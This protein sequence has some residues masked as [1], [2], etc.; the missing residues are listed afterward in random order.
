MVCGPWVDLY[1][2][3]YTLQYRGRQ[4]LMTHDTFALRDHKMWRL[5]NFITKIIPKHGLLAP[6]L[7]LGDPVPNKLLPKFILKKLLTS[8]HAGPWG[9][10]LEITSTF[11]LSY[12]CTGAC[13]SW[14][15]PSS[16]G[17]TFLSLAYVHRGGVSSLLLLQNLNFVEPIR[18]SNCKKNSAWKGLW[19]EAKLL[20]LFLDFTE[21]FIV[22]SFL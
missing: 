19:F 8:L 13:S 10:N 9:S 6:K 11:M 21:D 4:P 7:S 12:S 17:H 16:F 18:A 3:L 2:R 14:G 15:R 5:Y 22:F 1:N 20:R